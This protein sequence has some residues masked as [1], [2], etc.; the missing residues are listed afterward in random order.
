M[1][2]DNPT[3]RIGGEHGGVE[4]REFG[5]DQDEIVERTVLANA[6]D[7]PICRQSTGW[8]YFARFGT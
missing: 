2:E 3:R 8:V 5:R 6:H 4:G 1:S 7:I